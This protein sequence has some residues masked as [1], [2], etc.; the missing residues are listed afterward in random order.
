M[1][2]AANLSNVLIVLF[3]SSAL[4]AVITCDAVAE[5]TFAI[6]VEAYTEAVNVPDSHVRSINV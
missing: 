5:K 6:S 1:F 3:G 4:K 2:K